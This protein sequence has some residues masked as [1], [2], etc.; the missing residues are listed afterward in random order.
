MG[1]QRKNWMDNVK[2]WTSLPMPELLTMAS[3]QKDWKSISANLSFMSSTPNDL[4][5]QW[6]ELNWIWICL[7]KYFDS[8]FISSEKWNGKPRLA[9]DLLIMFNI[10]LGRS[11]GWS[12]E[13]LET[14]PGEHK[15]TYITS[16][17]IWRRDVTGRKEEALDDFPGK[18]E[19]GP[20]SVRPTLEPFQRQQRENFREMEGASVGFPKCVDTCLN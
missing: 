4:I 11:H 6:I 2:E 3:C 13:G 19:K 5:S 1:Q 14:L 10:H 9:C 7:Y 15:A 17:I 18:N 12:A 16:L 20:S 8:P